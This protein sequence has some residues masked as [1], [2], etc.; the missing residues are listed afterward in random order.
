MEFMQVNEASFLE[1]IRGHFLEQ[2]PLLGLIWYIS[3]ENK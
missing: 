3:M 1:K 2:R